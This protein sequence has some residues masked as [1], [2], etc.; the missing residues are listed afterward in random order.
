[1]KINFKL[2]PHFISSEFKKASRNELLRGSGTF[3]VFFFCL[4]LLAECVCVCVSK[5]LVTTWV[6]GWIA[7]LFRLFPVQK[8]IKN[9]VA[10][11]RVRVSTRVLVLQPYQHSHTHIFLYIDTWILET[12]SSEILCG[13]F[14][15]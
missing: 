10:K 4:K 2:F 14:R 5:N 1:M 13:R 9:T 8:G 3:P 6:T 7:F 15:Q 11:C 12:L